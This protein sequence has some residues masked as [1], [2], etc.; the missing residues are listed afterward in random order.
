MFGHG[1]GE[2]HLEVGPDGRL[3]D[4]RGETGRHGHRVGMGLHETREDLIRG[5]VDERV[6]GLPIIY[7]PN[8]YVALAMKTWVPSA[9]NASPRS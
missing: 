8:Q 7:D 1:G 4:K 2:D 9:P 6:A 5:S 3:P